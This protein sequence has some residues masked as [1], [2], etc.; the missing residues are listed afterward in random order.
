MFTSVYLSLFTCHI[1]HV[2]CHKKRVLELFGEGS[3]I[4]KAYPVFVTPLVQP[5]LFYKHLCHSLSQ[6]VSQSVIVL[7]QILRTP[8]I[9]NLKIQDAEMMIMFTSPHLS[10]V[11][12]HMSCVTC[13]MS[14]F[15]YFFLLVVKLVGGGSVINEPSSSSFNRFQVW[16]SGGI[17]NI[18]LFLL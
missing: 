16:C 5:G 9:P 1:S 17:L 14:H 2:Q 3:V 6:S 11:M 7:F 10:C 4:K 15:I 18:I 13:N 8:S 12:C